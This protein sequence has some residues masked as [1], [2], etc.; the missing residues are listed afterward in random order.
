MHFD[1]EFN[2]H[3]S[4]VFHGP[5]SV[6]HGRPRL[7]G[8]RLTNRDWSFLPGRSNR[9][10]RRNLQQRINYTDVGEVL[11][12]PEVNHRATGLCWRAKDARKFKYVDDGLIAC[13]INMRS[14]EILSIRHNGKICQKKHDLLTQKLFRRVVAR[15]RE[16]GMV[17]NNKKT[18]I[19]C[20]RCPEL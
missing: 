11:F 18:R 16:R 5:L 2:F 13:K 12:A 10:R 20:F 4:L 9:R 1:R 3:A 17:V 14:G 8:P 15:A 6:C 7:R 19:L